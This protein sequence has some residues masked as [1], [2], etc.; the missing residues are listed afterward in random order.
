MLV[1]C[2]ELVVFS[3]FYVF[4][5]K[6][7]KI[8]HPYF[9][10]RSKS[11]RISV[12]GGDFDRTKRKYQK[13]QIRYRRR[14]EAVKRQDAPYS[15]VRDDQLARYPIHASAGAVPP[16]TASGL[17]HRETASIRIAY[18]AAGARP[19]FSARSADDRRRKA[20]AAGDNAKRN[21][22]FTLPPR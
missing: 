17:P 5:L 6:I 15:T 22:I 12:R 2:Y 11:K 4:Y 3:F 7:R 14:P 13:L 8:R 19:A 18:T 20:R 9:A 16:A 1:P 21:I 10:K